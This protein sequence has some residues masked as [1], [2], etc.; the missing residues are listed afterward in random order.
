MP[1]TTQS[2]NRPPLFYAGNSPDLAYQV[3][4]TQVPGMPTLDNYQ[5]DIQSV[6]DSIYN[7]GASRLDP[8]FAQR[9]TDMQEQLAARGLP[10][11]SSVNNLQQ[12]QFGRDMSD[13]YNNLFQQSNLA[14]R[15]EH[16][17]LFGLGMGAHQQGMQNQLNQIGLQNQA[18]GQGFNEQM[19]VR[20]QMFS[21]MSNM[22]RSAKSKISSTSPRSSKHR[23]VIPAARSIRRLRT[24]FS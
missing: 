22:L 11:G 12:D 6:S 10:I 1:A 8:M 3:D 5:Q 13:A 15:Q 23:L 7:Q 16:S 2:G 18:R 9:Q 20:Q 21:E 17:R 4:Q 14:G 24:A 19:G